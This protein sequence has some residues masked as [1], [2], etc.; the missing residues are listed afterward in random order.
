MIVMDSA[1]TARAVAAVYRHVLAA[2]NEQYEA[3]RG[4]EVTM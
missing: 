2:A 4:K 3:R 1:P